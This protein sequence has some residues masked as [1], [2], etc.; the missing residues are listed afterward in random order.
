VILFPDN[1]GAI[2]DSNRVIQGLWCGTPL[3][4]LER[5][6]MKSFMA[7][8]HKFHLYAY[9][10]LQGIP[11]GV[12]VLD[13]N[14]IVPHERMK[15][16]RWFAGFSD[17]FRYTLLLKGGWYVDMD[18]VCFRPLDFTSEYV[19]AASSCMDHEH[20]YRLLPHSSRFAY[21]DSTFVGDAFLKAPA[22]STLMNYCRDLVD[23]TIRKGAS[24]VPYDG[25]GPRLFK[26]AIIKFGLEQ[27]VLAPIVFD[28]ITLIP[29]GT[30]TVPWEI[31]HVVRPGVL[32]DLRDSYVAHFSG[33]RW[34][35]GP[36][37]AGLMPDDKHP[38]DC[39]Y[40]QLK[41]KYGLV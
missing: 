23:E 2:P 40:E 12:V 6:C 41:K 4:N 16:F 33:S 11:E 20:D 22:N 27:Y 30:A 37:S 32:W 38:D 14:E 36:H 8:G 34:K 17:F 13:A 28:P 21:Q 10:E 5:L 29:G 35:H 3:S 15:E 19:F 18:V 39:L 24:D 7:N 26:K 31:D 1:Q 9:D 25:F